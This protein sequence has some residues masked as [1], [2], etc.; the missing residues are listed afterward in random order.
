MVCSLVARWNML[1]LE[2]LLRYTN[3]IIQ[4]P[5]PYILYVMSLFLTYK[6]VTEMKWRELLRNFI[7]LAV[8]FSDCR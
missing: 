3:A 7:E 1:R 2:I 5:I 6:A 4:C 8:R